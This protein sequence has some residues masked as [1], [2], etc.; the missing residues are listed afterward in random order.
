MAT[1]PKYGW[2]IPDLGDVADGPA[3][4]STLAVGIENTIADKTISTYTPSWVSDGVG[5]PTNPSARAGWYRVQNGICTFSA[6]IIFDSSTSGGRGDLKIGLP[7]P[8]S[9]TVSRQFAGHAHLSAPGASGADRIFGVISI[10]SGD[11]GYA[12]PWFPTSGTVS[13]HARWRV[14]DDGSGTGTT[15]VPSVSSGWNVRNGGYV[16]IT[17]TYFT[18]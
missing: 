14:A 6:Q 16:A 18:A 13:N 10:G 7:V 5:Q 11:T 1:T 3:A 9:G 17:G 4:F 8:A 15:G 2:T 12:A